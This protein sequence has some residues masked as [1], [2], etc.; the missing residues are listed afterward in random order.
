MLN[1]LLGILPNASEHGIHIDQML[2]FVHWMMLILFVGWSI[3]LVFVLFRF[4]KSRNAK[5]DYYGAKTKITTHLEASVV[6]V[7]AVLLIGFAFPLWAKRVNQF[8]INQSVRV[9]AIGQQFLWSFHYPG[10]DGKFGRQNVDLVTATNQIGLDRTD[11]DAQDDI[12]TVN[13]LHLPLNKPAIVE[14]MSKD[15]IHN[16]A[17]PYMRTAQDAIPGS[18]IPVWLTPTKAGVYEIICGQLCG[19]GHYA[20]RATLTVDNE[21]DYEKWNKEMAAL[22]PKPERQPAAEPHGHEGATEPAGT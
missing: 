22:I 19:L 1:R 4:H 3:F 11:P 14:I 13:D 20:M 21:Q 18:K 15:V 17:L 9:H 7:E 6:I 12:V 2:E 8:P 16:F 10:P 5:A